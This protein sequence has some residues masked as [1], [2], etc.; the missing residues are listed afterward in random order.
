MTDEQF[1]KS[2][3]KKELQLNFEGRFTHYGIVSFLLFIALFF[4][5]NQVN[6]YLKNQMYIR[7]SDIILFIVLPTLLSILY[8]FIQKRKLKLIVIDTSL[9]PKEVSDIFSEVASEQG[10]GVSQQTSNILIANTPCSFRSGSWG[11]Q[12][13]L[14]LFKNQIFLN[15]ICDPERRPS[16][17]S[18]GRNKK[19]QLLLL[20][21]LRK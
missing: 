14:L 17:V 21:K 9:T 6:D 13:T 19:N 3:E 2:I 5:L 7:L 16:I 4:I 15:S 10:W 8:Y 18:Y 12:V 11:E 20:N 1:K